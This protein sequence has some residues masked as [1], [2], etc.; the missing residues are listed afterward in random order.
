MR[1]YLVESAGFCW[2]VK[3]ALDRAL[4]IAKSDGP[5]YSYGPLV[6]NRQVMAEMEKEH[7]F[8]VEADDAGISSAGTATIVVRAHGVRPEVIQSLEKRAKDSGAKFHDLTCPLV[9]MVHNVIGGNAKRGWDTVIVGDADHA[10]VIGLVGYGTPGRTH[11]VANA[12]E[13][14]KLP[15]FERVCVVSQTTQDRENFETTAEVV[16]RKSRTYRQV[17]TI[18][19]P[20]Q[21]RQ[22]ETEKLAHEVKLVV[23]V[24]GKHSANTVRLVDLLKQWGCA[25]IHVETE[26][27][28]REEDFAGFDTVGVTAGLSTPQWMIDRVVER[29]ENIGGRA[30][31]TM[32]DVLR[33]AGSFLVNTNLYVAAGAAGL[34]AAAC[35]LQG[36]PIQWP[37]L[38]VPALFVQSMH[39]LNRFI[40]R[41]RLDFSDRVATVLY[42]RRPVP[43][44]VL[45]GAAGIAS[46]AIA[47]LAGWL[48]LTLA[49]LGL[50]CGG[51]YGFRVLPEAITF[52][53]GIRRLKDIPASRDL[54][55]AIGWTMMT[56]VFP[57]LS[58]GKLP[59][60]TN[61]LVFLA[62]FCMV[63]LRTTALGIR[64]V[65]GDKIVGQETVFKA[66]GRAAAR[67]L[68]ALI[69]L[70]LAG[71]LGALA[72]A[73]HVESALWLTPVVAYVALYSIAFFRWGAPKGFLAEMVTD[74]QNLIV[75]AIVA[76][77]MLR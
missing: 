35:T 46:V 8:G 70:V 47:A 29:L 60:P 23:V 42:K 48:P 74:G 44:L 40:D 75:G 17:N 41:T 49:C 43:L 11:V 22:E 71:S 76:A 19:R 61:L 37:F 9:R 63:F 53:L 32:G 45:G 57:F 14:E 16:K 36:I 56:T 12:K 64:D 62:V 33:G 38:V 26:T 3:E 69:A 27:E 21:E 7:V 18:C 1:V 10:E 4:E 66:L 58:V 30:R 34:A 6:H 68:A 67:N 50:V 25:A 13:A 5:V 31:T 28:L 73:L 54:S 77:M 59:G 52:R 20:T 72:F 39:T 65:A 55:T 51:V 2:G 24:G 15:A